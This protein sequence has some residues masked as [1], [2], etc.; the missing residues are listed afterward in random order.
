MSSI[1]TLI[2]YI[3]SSINESANGSNNYKY[4]AFGV[5]ID[6][7]SAKIY[8]DVATIIYLITCAIGL[9]GN[10]FNIYV[11]LRSWR[12]RTV[13]N[14]L[15]FHISIA[16]NLFLVWIPFYITFVQ[17][18]TWIW[19]KVVCKILTSTTSV[20]EAASTFFIVVL[21]VDRYLVI[22]H[23]LFANR[24]RTKAKAMIT[25]LIVW[26]ISILSMMHHF[27]YADIRE[28]PV[29][30]NISLSYTSC[31]INYPVNDLINGQKFGVI[32]SLIIMFFVPFSVII[33]LCLLIV[34]R[35]SKLSPQSNQSLQ[36]K[37]S[38][39]KMTYVTLGVII[40]HLIGLFPFLFYHVWL[41]I[42]PLKNLSQC[43]DA[44]KIALIVTCF[45]YAHP[46][47]H[48]FFFIFLIKNFPMP[49]LKDIFNRAKWWRRGSMDLLTLSM[50]F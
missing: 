18:A 12:E 49:Q 22:C 15:I 7:E 43:L 24:H 29:T 32:F 36:V 45:A 5:F 40:M 26:I 16:I 6:K 30:G 13:T 34:S 37:Q 35:L 42:F 50:K 48:V 19:S 11:I 20:A 47:I 28:F 8:V 41:L 23:P 25:C 10:T 1:L 33:F 17:E 9:I 3:S 46:A 31:V 38:K 2:S 27:I 39:R 21:S 4:E 44:Q 14:I